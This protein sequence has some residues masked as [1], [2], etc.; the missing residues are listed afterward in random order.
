MPLQGSILQSGEVYAKPETCRVSWGFAFV[1]LHAKSD[2][3]L[4]CGAFPKVFQ[5]Y[6]LLV[7]SSCYSLLLNTINCEIKNEDLKELSESTQQNHRANR[8]N[9]RSLIP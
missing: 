9:G 6:I 1:T 7:L 3:E 4:H 2:L 5:I 8:N